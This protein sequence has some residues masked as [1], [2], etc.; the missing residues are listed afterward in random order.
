DPPWQTRTDFAAFH[1]IAKG[2]SALARDHLGERKD[3][4]AVPLM[5][6]TPDELATPHGAVRDWREPGEMPTPGRDF[7]KIVVVERDYGAV[8]E[9]MAALGP[10][11]D[12]LGATTKGVT[13]QV[14][15]EIEKLARL[16]G[17]VHDG[18]A[19]GRPSLAR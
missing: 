9:K 4:V 10:L 11:L 6:D 13:F 7:P 8:A 18:V 1:A 17:V 5:H 19:A 12:N 14:G 3:L 2:L 15:P 16:N